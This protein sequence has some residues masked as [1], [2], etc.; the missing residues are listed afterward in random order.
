MSTN[1]SP[2]V[3]TDLLRIHRVITR[4][5]TVSKQYSQVPGPEPA[6]QEGFRSYVYALGIFLN[7]H[8][9]NEDEVTFPFVEKKAPNPTFD[10]LREQHRQ[11]VVVL[12]GLNAWVAKDGASWE[13]ASLVE[14]NKTISKL[15]KLWY[16][17]IAIEEDYIGPGAIEQLLTA[18]EDAKL[19]EQISAMAQQHSQPAELVVPFMIYNMT[20]DDR[21]VVVQGMPPVILEQLIPHAWKAAWAPMQPFLLD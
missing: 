7:S 21:A 12:K 10:Q 9:I 2:N 16:E 13:A 17:H 18:E 14:L 15:E 11:I 19:S 4:A 5:I 3:G 20:A 6:L 8:H 1:N